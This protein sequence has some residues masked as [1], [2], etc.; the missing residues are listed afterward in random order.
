MKGRLNRNRIESVND[1][2]GNTFFG[3]EVGN[4]FVKHFK[5]V[6]GDSSSVLPI[7]DPEALFVNKVSDLDSACMFQDVSK[8]E[9]KIAMFDID[10]DKAPGHDGYSSKFF[11][12]AWSIVGNEV[13]EAIRDFFRYGKLLGEL[14]ATIIGLVPKMKTPQKVSDFRP[15]SCCNVV[16]KCISKVIAN[17]L[18]GVLGDL[19]NE[20]QS[21]FIPK[22]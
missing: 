1:L 8:E 15:I 12:A 17:R 9:I 7:C 18:K 19:V 4:Q 14:N 20:C 13:C 2:N 5:S 21:A 6:L 16:Y 10:D 22:R 11:K 3:S